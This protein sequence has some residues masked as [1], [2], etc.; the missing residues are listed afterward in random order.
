MTFNSELAA[1]I[2]Q[3]DD[4][5][6]FASYFEGRRPEMRK[7]KDKIDVAGKKAQASI[8]VFQGAPGSGKTSLAKHIGESFARPETP[9]I[10]LSKVSLKS[11][12]A[13]KERMLQGALSKRESATASAGTWAAKAVDWLSPNL[14]DQMQRNAARMAMRGTT[15]I[16]HLDE[17]HS[18]DPGQACALQQLHASGLDEDGCVHAIV[19]LTG[20]QHTASALRAIPGLTRAADGNVMNL[21]RL[22]DDEC[23]RSTLRMLADLSPTNASPPI[24]KQ[25]TSFS[26]QASFGWPRHL[27]TAQSAICAALLKAKGDLRGI[28]IATL[29]AQTSQARDAY[30]TERAA[31]I[32]ESR[33]WR[34]AI[35]D[36]LRKIGSDAIPDASIEAEEALIESAEEVQGRTL[37]PDAAQA[38]VKSMMAHGLMESSEDEIWRLPIPSMSTWAEEKIEAHLEKSASPSP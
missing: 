11:I 37:T 35:Q 18:I 32:H 19:I 25:N 34:R 13:L 24:I 36:L 31:D 4:P 3:K 20:L 7:V 5:R 9:F 30:Y 29:E 2:A 8:I 12:D 27:A 38:I 10:P 14:T 26:A 28:D 22:S 6:D 33:N 15:F 16:L 23:E 17:A 21:S 1:E